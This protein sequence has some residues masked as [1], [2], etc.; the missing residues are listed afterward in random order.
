[1]RQPDAMT[2]APVLVD[3][4]FE[5]RALVLADAEAWKAGEDDEQIRWFEAPGPAPIE[6]VIAAARRWQAGW[7]DDGPV[8]HWGIWRDDHLAGGVELRIR[9]DGR[10]SVS[11][12]VFPA[13][14]T[15]GI[16]AR[17]VRLASAWVSETLGVLRCGRRHR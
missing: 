8:R 14:R 12:V 3:D 10:A 13:W 16:A 2:T 11:Y 4:G 5:L 17:A 7:A 15:H 6:N 1:M 9:H